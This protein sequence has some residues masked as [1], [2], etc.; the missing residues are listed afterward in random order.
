VDRT[1]PGPPQTHAITTI[2]ASPEL[3]LRPLRGSTSPA[4]GAGMWRRGQ[5][6][7]WR[8]HL[9][10]AGGEEAARWRGVAVA[11]AQ[12]WGALERP[13]EGEEERERDGVVRGSSGW[14]L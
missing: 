2:G 7:I 9:E 5:G 6:T 11:G 3:G 1:R 12:R 4:K 13:G 14:L 10:L 8:P